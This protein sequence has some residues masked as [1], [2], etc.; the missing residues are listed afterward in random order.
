MDLDHDVPVLL[1]T[2]DPPTE[3]TWRRL[4]DSWERIAPYPDDWPLPGDAF[5]VF[6]EAD[7]PTLCTL[8]HFAAPPE[9]DPFP[10]RIRLFG[11]CRHRG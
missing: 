3:P 8:M 4:S 7:R 2:I 1:V 10:A 11:R 5:R 9:P 6:T